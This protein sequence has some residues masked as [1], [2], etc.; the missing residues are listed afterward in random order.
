MNSFLYEPDLIHI[1]E[2]QQLLEQ[3]HTLSLEPVQMYGKPT[4]RRIVSFGLDYRASA[5][6]LTVAPSIP[7]F[8][9]PVRERAAAI[10]GLD[11]TTL[12]QA[13]VT[14]YPAGASIGW[15]VDHP[16]FGDT[17]VAVSLQG[18][19][20]LQLRPLRGAT[21][22]RQTIS[23]RSAYVLRPDLRYGHEHHVL[24]HEDR[25]SVT[26]RSIAGAGR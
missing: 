25:V 26:F 1:D 21:M 6:M 7:A 11:P 19:A 18:R 13:L 16:Q 8:L 5:R 24:A 10:A 20:T 14:A 9:L 15:H 22:L 23:P 4:K 12:E 2:E 17:V 3:L